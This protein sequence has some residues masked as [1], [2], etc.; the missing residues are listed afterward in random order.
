MVPVMVGISDFRKTCELPSATGKDIGVNWAVIW[1]C[2]EIE[3]LGAYQSIT[4][5]VGKGWSEEI[6]SWVN[7]TS[8][9]GGSTGHQ[10]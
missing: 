9:V 5:A 8:N 7:G 1:A 10:N 2:R 4:V 6:T 3:S